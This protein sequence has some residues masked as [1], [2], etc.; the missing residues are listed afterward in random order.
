MAVGLV[1]GDDRRDARGVGDVRIRRHVIAAD[2]GVARRV[3]QIDVEKAVAGVVG[4]EGEAEQAALA[5]SRD[6]AGHIEE[7][8]RENL[9]GGEI[10]DFDLPGFLDQEQA[11]GVAG[12]RGREQRLAQPDATRVAMIAVAWLCG[13]LGS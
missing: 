4:I 5:S 9:S 12:R 7:R 1:D 3:D 11:A 8:R 13:P 10:E 6:L 2:L